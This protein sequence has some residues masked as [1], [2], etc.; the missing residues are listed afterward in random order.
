MPPIRPGYLFGE[1]RILNSSG[2]FLI[3][4]MLLFHQALLQY[5]S[6]KSVSLKKN[7]KKIIKPWKQPLL[8]TTK[9]RFL[10][11]FTVKT[12]KILTMKYVKAFL[13]LFTGITLLNSC[14]KEFSMESNRI[15][16]PAG[17]WEFKDSTT[18]FSGTMDTAFISGNSGSR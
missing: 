8:L 11:I 18:E 5:L 6:F 14:A 13:I 1:G 4:L 15:K 16:T 2:P 17:N 10:N 9:F 3:L 7:L 12:L